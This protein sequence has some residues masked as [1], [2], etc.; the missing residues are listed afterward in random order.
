MGSSYPIITSSIPSS[1]HHMNFTSP[2]QSVPIVHYN[3]PT[4]NSYIPTIPP[5]DI[6][7]HS[8]YFSTTSTNT[9]LVT[10]QPTMV[11]PQPPVVHAHNSYQPKK[12]P[13]VQPRSRQK[14]R[15]KSQ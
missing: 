15:S 4:I 11:Q 3:N 2:I 9:P 5:G 1:W 7:P 6:S 12:K 14:S 10:G 8:P 13:V